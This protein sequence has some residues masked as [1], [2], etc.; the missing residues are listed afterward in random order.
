MFGV[1]LLF[2]VSYSVDIDEVFDFENTLLIILIF[3]TLWTTMAQEEMVIFN[4]LHS[5]RSLRATKLRYVTKLFGYYIQKFLLQMKQDD[6]IVCD[7][8]YD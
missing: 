7:I 8:I 3:E 1:E 6:L 2:N 4:F 5:L